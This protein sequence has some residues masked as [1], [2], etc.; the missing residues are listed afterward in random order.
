LVFR[1]LEQFLAS[2]K[3]IM[4]QHERQVRVMIAS[5]D[6]LRA[7]QVD[8]LL[9][10]QGLP[11]ASGLVVSLDL[12]ADRASRTNPDMLVLVLGSD[13]DAAVS[14]VRQTRNSCTAYI[15]AVGP[16]DDA[17]LI[18]R[19][20]HEGADEYLDQARFSE[21]LPGAL[22]RFGAKRS[23]QGSRAASGKV[24]SVIGAS[25]GAGA[26]TIAANIAGL[27]AKQERTCGLVDLR[28]EA[29]D[30]AALLG[31][32]PQH[33]LAEFCANAGR[34]DR[35]V[36][37]QM[38]CRHPSGLELLAAP[39]DPR[40][41]S[42]VT[43]QSL[44]LLLALSRAKFQ[45]LLM[46]LDNRL[47]EVQVEAL[48]QSDLILAV[49][50]LD[51]LSVRNARRLLDRLMEMGIEPSRIRIV[52]NRY[53]QPRELTKAQAESALGAKI[54]SFVIDDAGRVNL[55]ANEGKL[56]AIQS[57]WST[58]SRNLGELAASVNGQHQ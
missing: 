46:D 5:D 50:R 35:N 43:P 42:L 51:F 3:P 17:K 40:Q 58:I 1:R 32:A 44:R 53:K 23:L 9:A 25:G 24:I 6:E 54:T 20:L 57:R 12:A 31:L 30:Q 11:V 27:L 26:S 10:K 48:W 22:A 14:V 18:L 49:T 55:S 15:I 36:L 7:R 2:G 4:Q 56:V 19:C 39:W 37:D 34:I 47:A 45:Y 8:E 52:A 38:F 13:F 33:T 21:D 29:G 41:A 28:L 16:A